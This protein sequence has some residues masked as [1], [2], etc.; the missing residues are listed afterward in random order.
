MYL[1]VTAPTEKEV[2]SVQWRFSECC[3][4]LLWKDQQKSED[5]S[6]VT[7]IRAAT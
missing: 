4:Q 2:A 7:G 1:R 3:E 6:K 5:F